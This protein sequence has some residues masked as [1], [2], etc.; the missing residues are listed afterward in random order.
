MRIVGG[1]FRGRVLMAPV[2]KVTRPTADRVREALFD[3]LMSRALAEGREGLEGTAMLDVFAGTGALGF[4]ALSRG[5]DRVTFIENDPTALGVIGENVRKLGV[6][7][8]ATLLRGDATQPPKA[9][10]T[11]DLVMLDAPYRSGLAAPALVALTKRGWIAPG[12][13]IIV[14]VASGEPFPSPDKT[15]AVA[16]ER[17]YGA[18]KLIFLA[19][20]TS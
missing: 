8:R 20:V 14:E 16:D 18:A 4:E 13:T 6:G 19:P 11:F 7:D 5:A 12:A 15:L 9:P 10:A 3:I 2:N 17:R 1:T